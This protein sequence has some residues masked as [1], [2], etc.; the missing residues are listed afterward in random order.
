MIGVGVKDPLSGT[1][2]Q[3][4][5][6]GALRVR[7]QAP[8]LIDTN[9]ATGDAF[10]RLRISAPV[11]L[12]DNKQLY[13]DQPLFWDDQEVSGAGTT[14][15]HSTA[16][17]STTMGVSAATAGRRVRQTYQR[18]NYQPGKSQLVFMTGVLDKEG[19]GGDGITRRMGLYDDNNG[20]ILQKQDTTVSFVLR[21]ASSGTP[22]DTVVSR[23]VWNL[24]T[25]DGDGPSGIGLDFT[26]TQI[27]VL[28]FEWLGVGRVRMGFNVNG[29]TIYAHEFNHGNELDV[30][31]LSDPNLPLRLEIENDGTGGAAEIEHICATVITEG[32]QQ[33]IASGRYISQQTEGGGPVNANT[34][35]VIYA[36]AGIRLK[37][38]HLGTSVSVTNIT[39]LG[40]ASDDYE[41][42]VILNP[43]IAGTAPTWNGLTNSAVEAAIGDAVGNPSVNTV[44]L[45]T[46]LRGGLATAGNIAGFAF[47]Q[48]IALAS[49]IGSAIDGTPDEMWLCARALTA[50]ADIEGGINFRED[51]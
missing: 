15:V 44:T 21:S 7:E 47:D 40:Q 10:G 46:I 31:Y 49:R 35:G 39:M 18:F 20:F 48:D 9:N 16:R 4:E 2:A 3:V 26:K 43:T 24:D 37:S 29:V 12:F 6:D 41:W 22:F 34:A 17:A 32:G 23:N 11:T 30:V 51:Q 38:T 13:D 36:I 50:N 8:N 33:R 19:I 42:L 45:G 25:F 1:Q 14:S 28:D 5:P 27:L